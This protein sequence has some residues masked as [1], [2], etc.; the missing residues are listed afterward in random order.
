VEGKMEVVTV[1]KL[2]LED[3]KRMIEAARKHAQSLGGVCSFAVV[4]DAGN[5]ICFERMDGGK[6]GNIEI[7]FRKAWT[8]VAFKR[9]TYEYHERTQPGKAG[10]GL[11]FTNPDRACFIRGGVVIKADGEVVGG[12]GCSGLPAEKDEECVKVGIAAL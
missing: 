8:A 7:A 5:L 12:M 11:H 1:K 4:D 3:A 2:T 6:I 9:D 10:F